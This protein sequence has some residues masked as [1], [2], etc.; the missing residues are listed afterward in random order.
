MNARMLVALGGAYLLGSIPFGFL[1]ARLKGIDIRTQGSG[2]IGATN[3]FRVVGRN[4]GIAVLALD[5]LKGFLAVALARLLSEG[6]SHPAFIPAAGMA[7]ILG[8]TFPLWLRFKGGKGVATSL[9]VFLAV[10]WLPTLAAFGFW[11]F[12]FALTRIISAASLAAAAVFPFFCYLWADAQTAPVLVPLSVLLTLFI[13]YTHRSNL[14]RLW[15]R[16]E[17]KLF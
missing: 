15:R 16:E 8:H 7:G 6:S 13:V 10:S 17:K 3:V 14:R 4:W 11:T 2:N 5:A 12:V 9:G 1:T